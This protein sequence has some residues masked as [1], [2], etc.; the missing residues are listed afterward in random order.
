MR[1]GRDAAGAHR[2]PGARQH[3]AL[4]FRAGGNVDARLQLIDRGRK[5]S[6]SPHIAV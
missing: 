5:V 2:R 6:F 3:R 1:R 4:D